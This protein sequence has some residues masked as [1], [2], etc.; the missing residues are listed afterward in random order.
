MVEVLVQAT[1]QHIVWGK[2]LIENLVLF[3]KGDIDRMYCFVRAC[4]V[5]STA[6]PGWKQA[7]VDGIL[8]AHHDEFFSVT[9]RKEAWISLEIEERFTAAVDFL[10][11]YYILQAKDFV[12]I[13][14]NGTFLLRR[15][16]MEKFVK[17]YRFWKACYEGHVSTLQTELGNA[18][19]VDPEMLV[20]CKDIRG[21]WCRVAAFE[22]AAMNAHIDCCKFLLRGFNYKLALPSWREMRECG[23]IPE[24][25]V[26]QIDNLL[27]SHN[28]GWEMML[29]PEDGDTIRFQSDRRSETW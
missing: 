25:I 16:L 29:A 4:F 18:G 6:S 21:K 14:P 7:V 15:Q 3:A 2:S 27:I 11:S 13:S 20:V 12:G 22:A 5:C 28:S 9:L 23:S 8:T 17:D 26:K 24:A 10:W 1:T 19:D